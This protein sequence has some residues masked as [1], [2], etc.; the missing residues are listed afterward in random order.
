M[1]NRYIP[2]NSAKRE[3]SEIGVI[4]YTFQNEK[5]NQPCAIAYSGKRSKA[6]F[7][8][9]FAN[10]E[11]RE[12]HIRDYLNLMY[13]KMK[14]KEERIRERL[15]F[16]HT[17]KVGDILTRSWGY[18]QT[19]VDFYQVVE[20]KEKM[21]KIR[22]IDSVMPNG[23][24]GFMTGYVI[25]IKDKF[26]GEKISKRKVLVGNVIKIN[27]HAYAYM[28]NGNPQRVSWYG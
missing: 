25:P 11:Q 14:R 21:V 5:I 2:P 7:H 6:D 12:K 15:A 4:I 27:N 20:L 16:K 3:F 22:E 26:I 1:Q 13:D 17:L 19:N 24:E 10:M 8:F 18:E 28:W 9:R 23:E